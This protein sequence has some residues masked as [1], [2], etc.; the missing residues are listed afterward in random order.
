MTSADIQVAELRRG[1]CPTLPEPMQ[2]GDGLLARLSLAAPMSPGQAAGLAE[3]AKGCGNGIIEV[4]ARGKL[5]LRG[6]DPAGAA[7]L[8]RGVVALGLSV[9]EGLGIETSALAGR[10][11]REGFDPRP[12][13]AMIGQAATATGLAGRLAPK[14]SVGIDS[15]GVLG[16]AGRDLDIRVSPADGGYRIEAAGVALG[17]TSAAAPVVLGLLERLSAF[18][19]T[20]R[21]R[22][23]LRETGAAAL[24]AGLESVDPDAAEPGEP[25]GRH[26]LREGSAFGLALAFGQMEATALSTLAQQAEALGASFIEP[27]GG[28]VLLVGPLDAAGADAL[29]AFAGKAGFIMAVG[30]PLRRVEACSGAPAC[31]SARMPTHELA[32]EL[33]P[34][35]GG[36]RVHV[37]GCIKGCAHPGKADLTIVGLDEGAGIVIEGTPRDVPQRIVPYDR[38]AFAAHEVLEIA[39]GL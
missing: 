16:L 36:R 20:A 37:S 10:D 25:V 5:Q 1:A 39:G 35:A 3:L 7:R 34:L 14:L 24:G 22:D 15:G 28:R 38:L 21:M 19:A 31:G 30:D 2:T 8:A 11:P 18:G 12:L 32:R 27:A 9:R 29:A 6:L 17:W 4:T 23:L 33:A 26:A 13:A